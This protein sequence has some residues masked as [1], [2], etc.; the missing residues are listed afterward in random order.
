MHF[1]RWTDCL[2]Q[3]H[4]SDLAVH[5]YGNV[6]PK[7][8][9]IKQTIMKARISLLEILDHLPH[10]RAFDMKRTL[11]SGERLEQRRDVNRRQGQSRWLQIA[12]IMAG[13]FMG[14]RRIR[15]HAARWMALAMAAGGGTILASPTP[16]APNG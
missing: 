10:R 8:A 6:G 13:G 5:G 14:S 4:G 16:R 3:A 7:P 9:L 11:T 12:S 1:A 2:E 15:T